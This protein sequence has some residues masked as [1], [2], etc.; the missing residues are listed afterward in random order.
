MAVIAARGGL[1][2]RLSPAWTLGLGVGGVL[3]FI[4]TVATGLLLG[5]ASKTFSL[6]LAHLT[7]EL[8]VFLFQRRDTPHGIG[9][10]AAPI[11]GLLSQL[12]IFTP[13]SRHFGAQLIHF[14][15][16]PRKQRR[17]IGVSG[18]RIQRCK[19]HAIHNSCVVGAEPQKERWIGSAGDSGSTGSAVVYRVVDLVDLILRVE[20]YIEITIVYVH[21]YTL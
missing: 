5:A 13:Q 11:P 16:K 1:L 6:Q 12:Q 19:P 15:Q 8:L 3:Q 7:A 9:V 21:I 10:S 4:G 18:L 2:T 14:R 20:V 17:Q